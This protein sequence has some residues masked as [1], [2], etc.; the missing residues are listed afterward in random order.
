MKGP[1]TKHGGRWYKKSKFG[2]IFVKGP[3]T[4]HGGGGIKSQNSGGSL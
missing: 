4:K 3:F 1:F 2:K